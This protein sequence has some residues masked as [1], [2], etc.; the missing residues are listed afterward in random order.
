[1]VY[2]NLGITININ[3]ETFLIIDDYEMKSR[4]RKKW[5]KFS[6]DEQIQFLEQVRP[7]ISKHGII[8]ECLCHEFTESGN[9]HAHGVLQCLNTAQ[10]VGEIT[11]V[12]LKVFN[13]RDDFC[14]LVSPKGIPSE[15]KE[16]IFKIDFLHG[17]K[18]HANFYEYCHKENNNKQKRDPE[19]YIPFH[20][21]ICQ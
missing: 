20:C 11:E 1:M 2:N 19:E 7:I 4:T 14:R 18:D 21:M 10:T 17:E 3:P 16:R 8:I 15:I 9:V 12:I 5:K 6:T 13:I